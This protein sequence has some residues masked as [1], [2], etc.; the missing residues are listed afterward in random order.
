MIT[1]PA[2]LRKTDLSDLFG[3]SDAP[4]PEPSPREASTPEPVPERISSVFERPLSALQQKNRN[5]AFGPA[6]WYDE[7]I[8]DMKDL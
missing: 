6:G 7:F 4:S 1:L 3:S 5:E 8:H 2:Q